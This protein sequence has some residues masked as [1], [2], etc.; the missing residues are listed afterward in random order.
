MARAFQISRPHRCISRAMVSES[1][2]I[3][4]SA[5]TAVR[6][7][8]CCVVAF[9]CQCEN[10]GRGRRGQV[11]RPRCTSYYVHDSGLL[12]G[13]EVHTELQEVQEAVSVMRAGEF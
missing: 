2:R 7:S 13:E 10:D 11:I 6:S 9:R 8:W 1:V 4:L 12:A 5:T 3:I